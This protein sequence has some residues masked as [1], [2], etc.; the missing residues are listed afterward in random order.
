MQCVDLVVYNLHGLVARLFTYFIDY[1]K[2]DRI[3]RHLNE[4]VVPER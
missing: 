2:S 4:A 3:L 1:A